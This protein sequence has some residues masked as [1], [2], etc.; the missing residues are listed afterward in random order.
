MLVSMSEKIEFLIREKR[1]QE[2]ERNPV[3]D[4][5]RSTS[6]YEINLH[7]REVLV[8]FLRRTDFSCNGVAVLQGIVLYLAL[9]HVD[10]IRRVQI[11][12]I[13]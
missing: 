2:I 12:V 9:G 6:V 13:R 8:T 7:E 3:T 1:S 10:V 4:E 11:V 5:F